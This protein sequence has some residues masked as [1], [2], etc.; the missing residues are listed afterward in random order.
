[1]GIDGRASPA[2]ARRSFQQ[3]LNLAATLPHHPKAV[4]TLIFV[5]TR[6]RRPL[7]PGSDMATADTMEDS[8]HH[9]YVSY[10]CYGIL[11][12]D[13]EVGYTTTILCQTLL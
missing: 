6:L 2:F 11:A 9:K 1:V 8:V 4:Q 13:T 5:D 7:Q 3:Q 12:A 10:P